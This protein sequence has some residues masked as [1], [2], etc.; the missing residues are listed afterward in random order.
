MA[1]EFA[2]DNNKKLEYYEAL[3]S[4]NSTYDGIV[5]FGIRTTGIFCRPVC[6]ARKPKFENCEFF[7]STQAALLAGYRPC[8][9]CKP[10]TTFDSKASTIQRLIDA[11]EMEPDKR[12]RA[13]DF[14]DLGIGSSTIRRHFKQKFGMTFVAYARARRMG[15]AMQSI[16]N[17]TSVTGAQLQTGYD[18]S[19][20]F[21]DAFS[22][23][24][25]ASPQGFQ[26]RVLYCDWIDTPLGTMLAI[27]SDAGLCLLEF[28]DRR[29]LEREIERLSVRTKSVLLPGQCDPF[30]QIRNELSHYFANGN[31]QFKTPLEFIGTEFQKSVW[32]ELLRIPAGQTRTYAEQA[33]AVG[34]PQ[35]VRA[36]ARANGA[37]Q[38][39]I[40]VPCH[41]VIGAKGE[42]TGYSGG[43]A[44]KKWLID[45]ERR[46]SSS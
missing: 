27:G 31:F 16:R 5:Y 1:C 29:G 35:A 40:V 6:S 23:L 37:N 34:A 21:R 17:G 13:R 44:R 9:R 2:I 24:L 28:L 20:G 19:S 42:L 22:K 46:R 32:N 7:A 39:A 18:S 45:H 14:D 33:I 10:M 30:K 11:V 36:I 38:L 15:I 3:L 41:R 26:G 12:W 8:K 25:G 4:R 43:L